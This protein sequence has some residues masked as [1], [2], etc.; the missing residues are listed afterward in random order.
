MSV[1]VRLQLAAEEA[2]ARGGAVPPTDTGPGGGAALALVPGVSHHPQSAD[3]AAVA[4]RASGGRSVIG[5]RSKNKMDVACKIKQAAQSLILLRSVLPTLRLPSH[6][7]P[8]SPCPLCLLPPPQFLR[9]AT[10]HTRRCSLIGEAVPSSVGVESDY[11]FF[12]ARQ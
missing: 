1:D 9:A 5:A 11:G 6:L 7:H 3:L 8:R 4:A 2:V 10:T 12:L